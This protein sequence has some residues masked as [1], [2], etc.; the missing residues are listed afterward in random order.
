MR[1]ISFVGEYLDGGYGK[2]LGQKS[3]LKG[4]QQAEDSR[5]CFNYFDD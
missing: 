1:R 4:F 3:L 5:S 2:V